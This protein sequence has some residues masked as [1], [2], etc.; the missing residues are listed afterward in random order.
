MKLTDNLLQ[1]LSTPERGNRITYDDAVKGF[2]C[3]VTAASG[4]AFILKPP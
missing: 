1:R 3:R 4:R 2:G